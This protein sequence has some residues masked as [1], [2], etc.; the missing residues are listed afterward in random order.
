MIVDEA[1]EDMT[2]D[3]DEEKGK[4]HE[5]ND[6]CGELSFK[7]RSDWEH[8]YAHKICVPSRRGLGSGAQIDGLHDSSMYN[9]KFDTCRMENLV[10]G[11]T[12][13]RR[14]CIL[15]LSR[16]RPRDMVVSRCSMVLLDIDNNKDW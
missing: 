8:I 3:L 7:S 16:R 5:R 14:A 2:V 13:I 6:S 11:L 1:C 15:S 10:K 4:A 12:M 9:S